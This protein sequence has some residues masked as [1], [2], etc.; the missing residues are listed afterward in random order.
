MLAWGKQCVDCGDL[1]DYY[2]VYDHVW[3]EAGLDPNQCCC[4][5]QVSVGAPGPSTQ[6]RRL[7]V[8][9][10]EH[11]GPR[12]EPWQRVT[13]IM[14]KVFVACNPV[15]RSPVVLDLSKVLNNDDLC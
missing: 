14:T 8:L 7:H 6:A 12:A 11:V 13:K 4:C 5:M 1:R 15:A 10:G 9:S 2:M 3:K